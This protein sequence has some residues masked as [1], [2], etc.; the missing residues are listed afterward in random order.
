LSDA[1]NYLDLLTGAKTTEDLPADQ[2]SKLL[3]LWETLQQMETS[4]T[5]AQQEIEA[6]DAQIK[7]AMTQGQMQAI[8]A[9]NLT[10][11]D[12][13]SIMQAQ[14]DGFG[15]N[16]QNNS[17]QNSTSS[18]NRNFPQ[19]GFGA[20][21]PPPENRVFSGA[22]GQG[23]SGQNQNQSAEQIATAQ[24]ARQANANRIPTL[25]LNALIEI[26]KKKAGS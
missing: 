7:E 17:Q 4:D 16:G 1:Q 25:L 11:Q 20:G 2:A 10:R 24:A 15:T 3:P 14:G 22:G 9:M 23:F 19:G 6:L 13:F 26:L 8:T 18:S 21:G 12:M 5:A